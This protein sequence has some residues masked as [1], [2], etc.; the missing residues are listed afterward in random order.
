MWS[1]GGVRQ[2]SREAGGSKAQ[3]PAGLCLGGLLEW[4]MSDLDK[5]GMEMKWM[6]AQISQGWELLG[7]RWPAESCRDLSCCGG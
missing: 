4:L 3:K 7:N 6:E 5:G 1:S 2:Q